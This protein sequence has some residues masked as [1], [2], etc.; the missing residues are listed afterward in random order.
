MASLPPSL[1]RVLAPI[2]TLLADTA[3]RR[4]LIDDQVHAQ[5]GEVWTTVDVPF[6]ASTLA[7]ALDALAHLLGTP[8]A[9]C[10]SMAL[11]DQSVLVGLRP[12][13]VETPT[14]M[15][16]RPASA[17]V[18][19]SDHPEA[20]ATIR[21][22]LARGLNIGVV[23]PADGSRLV[24]MRAI[25]G[26]LGDARWVVIDLP[27]DAAP[28]ALVLRSDGAESTAG[29]RDAVINAA[30]QS[31]AERVLLD[32]AEGHGAWPAMLGAARRT[33][34]TIIGL[35]GRGAQSALMGLI[36]QMQASRTGVA[37][38]N[39]VAAGLDLVVTV[40][41]ARLESV[42]AVTPAGHGPRLESLHR[43]RA[44]G[45]T[46]T[47]VAAHDPWHLRW[48]RSAPAATPPTSLPPESLTEALR[49]ARVHASTP[50]ITQRAV[51]ADRISLGEAAPPHGDPL[52][53]LL[54]S[55]GED[56]E[57][58]VDLDDEHEETMVQV[59]GI[60]APT[61]KRTFS[62]ILRSLGEADG[63]DSSM[64]ARRTPRVTRLR[65]DD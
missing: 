61:S 53:A 6:D 24:W 4:V 12:P 52:Q 63:P 33:V 54:A 11:D 13:V 49:M 32:L 38:R 36:A 21:L 41:G 19:L 5:Q 1:T 17:A 46:S 35:P 27:A 3:V 18:D 58:S 45:Q 25:A 56:D 55:L 62:E 47:E 29:E 48:Y 10:L 65:D 60:I 7:E 28:G 14:L 64:H 34:P 50:R 15:I 16:H 57:V 26:L 8:D 43:A 2:E 40:D 51:A 22:A 39:L 44:D 37:A 42:D 31:G 9:P 23:G 30:M 20:T 59:P